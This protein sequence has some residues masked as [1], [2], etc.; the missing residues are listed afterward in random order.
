VG[1]AVVVALIA[2]PVCIIFSGE[3]ID[4]VYRPWLLGLS[5]GLLSAVAMVVGSMH[6][7]GVGFLYLFQ[8]VSALMGSIVSPLVPS[9]AASMFDPSVAS[10]VQALLV[11]AVALAGGTTELISG[12]LDANWL[13]GFAI[14]GGIGVVAAIAYA[15]YVPEKPRVYTVAEA[16][17]LL[18]RAYVRY[19]RSILCAPSI[20]LGSITYALTVGPA[21]V[22]TAFSS[23]WLFVEKDV[24][25]G[26][27]N[28]R[29][30]LVQLAGGILV[31]PAGIVADMVSRRWGISRYTIAVLY[32]LLSISIFLVGLSVPYSSSFLSGF[33]LLQFFGSMQMVVSLGPFVSEF[34][35]LVPEDI[36][37]SVVA[38]NFGATQLYTGLLLS[39]A[40][41]A[42][43]RLE[44]DPE[45]HTPYTTVLTVLG[46]ISYLPAILCIAL[47]MLFERDRKALLQVVDASSEANRLTKQ[48]TQ[49]L[50][51]GRDVE[52]GTGA[53]AAPLS[54]AAAPSQG[55]D[56]VMVCG[57][58]A[59]AA[60]PS[61]AAAPTAT[62]ADH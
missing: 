44:K 17:P 29:L 26:D 51:R 30:G 59:A 25:V 36:H 9:M 32:Q 37:G 10:G 15:M 50:S 11:C 28:T 6:A 18:R 48:P 3:L 35:R 40:G 5:L 4:T 57:I 31:I 47:K 16:L 23:Q 33:W 20:A 45:N 21:L 34:L 46:V 52:Y 41:I 27:A 12:V 1:H 55:E 13:V 39:A 56:M 54:A 60:P 53:A 38:A 22:I 2:G 8:V 14:Y 7:V 42:L 24:P 49:S 43:D 19:V 58:G 61:A 62:E